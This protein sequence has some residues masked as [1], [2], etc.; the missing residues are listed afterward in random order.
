MD[1][2]ELT[3]KHRFC[4]LR[5][6]YFSH[7]E[8]SELHRRITGSQQNPEARGAQHIPDHLFAKS[9]ERTGAYMGY[10]AFKNYFED[11]GPAPKLPLIKAF[12]S[13]LA[14]EHVGLS[15]DPTP[16]RNALMHYITTGGAPGPFAILRHEV[17]GQELASEHLLELSAGQ[18]QGD[19]PF[20]ALAALPTYSPAVRFLS[21]GPPDDWAVLRH[22]AIARDCEEEL[23]A[24]LA[25][26]A[27]LIIVTGAAGDGKT[28]MLKRAGM[29]LREANW[30]VF[31]CEMPERAVFPKISDLSEQDIET[32]LLVDNADAAAG[33]AD[34]EDALES[35][36]RVHVV[37]CARSYNWQRKKFKFRRVVPMEVPRLAV[38]EIARLAGAIVRH[39]AA[40]A[41]LGEAEIVARIQA[42]VSSQH[43][44]LLAAMLTATRGKRFQEIIDDMIDDFV[45]QQDDWVLRF[46]ACG[47]LLNDVSADRLSRLPDRALLAVA[48]GRW[49]RDSGSLT[50]DEIRHRLARFDS[51]VVQLRPNRQ[52][53]TEY[54]LRHPD[55]AHRVMQRF[56]GLVPN[57][58]ELTRPETF[59]EDL[60]EIGQDEIIGAAPI[61]ANLHGRFR[62]Y[63]ARVAKFLLRP[64]HFGHPFPAET[65]RT[66]V[67]GLL[68]QLGNLLKERELK[69]TLRADWGAREL[70]RAHGRRRRLATML[71]ADETPEADG[72]EREDHTETLIQFQEDMQLS[73]ELFESALSEYPEGMIEIWMAWIDASRAHGEHIEISDARISSFVAEL[74]Q[75]TSRLCRR[76][77][78]AGIREPRLRHIWFRTE[79]A[80]AN[81]G[82][83]SAPDF[84]ARWIAR[85]DDWTETRPDSNFLFDWIELELKESVGTFKDP[86][87]YT[88]RWLFRWLLQRS[89]LGP[90]LIIRWLDLEKAAGHLDAD[91]EWSVGDI[92]RKAW[93]AGYRQTS[94]LLWWTR[95]EE[96]RGNIGEPLSN[97]PD[98]SARWIYQNAWEDQKSD[99]EFVLS[100]LDFEE[101]HEAHAKNSSATMDSQHHPTARWICRNAWQADSQH[102]ELLFRWFAI[103]TAEGNIGEP[104]IP[105]TA[106]WIDARIISTY[107]RWHGEEKRTVSTVNIRRYLEAG[108]KLSM[109]M[110]IAGV[111]SH[112]QEVSEPTQEA[113]EAIGLYAGYGPFEIENDVADDAPAEPVAHSPAVTSAGDEP[114]PGERRRQR[115]HGARRNRR[116]PPPT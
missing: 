59:A 83:L 17:P 39:G 68:G 8:Y 112:L 108:G 37:L 104:D 67:S 69:A 23:L 71:R 13:V 46:V 60:R 28:T 20:A 35:A 75:L 50:R 18:A 62:P 63:M 43:P 95:F 24:K 70:E 78:E 73:T 115:R 33:F 6:A 77:W 116:A 109:V 55:I 99:I 111:P 84:T 48:A 65:E 10:R 89:L 103:E 45:A 74:D 82:D 53:G 1:S 38:H 5:D 16:I 22:A 101:A 86:A 92:C 21:G 93:F 94:F 3:R 52:A 30:R 2:A 97:P 102:F 31:Y 79:V 107:P 7:L 106:A 91:L 96:E 113:L 34:I 32:L 49:Q 44:H 57:S 56:Y 14:R 105:H 72:D 81:I 66:L 11:D 41:K 61:I 100:W 98:Y 114:R 87:K 88:A 51:E 26:G 12:A 76:A 29:R 80:A 110:P 64:P 47:A 90:V 85:R 54:D 27:R 19:S 4:Y 25:D 42:S 9:E 58:H 36:P 40:S 15:T